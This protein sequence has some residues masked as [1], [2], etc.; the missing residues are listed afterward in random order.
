M[1]H[2]LFA[3]LFFL[4]IISFADVRLPAVIASHMV[5]QQ[6]A[7]VRIWGWCEPGEHVRVKASWDTATYT[8]NGSEKATWSVLIKTPVAGGPYTI[9]ITGFNK[10][11]LD[12]VML[13]EVWVCSGQSNM[14]M[15]MNWGLPYAAE[16]RAA[17][18]NNIRFF[19]IPRTS[20]DYPQDDLKARWA[21]SSEEEMK[22]FS[23]VAYFFG[24]RLQQELN[25]PIGLIHASWSGTPAEVWTPG[26]LVQSDSALKKAAAV[27]S[28]S[29]WWPVNPGAAF[30]AMLNPLT[31]FSISGAIYYQGESNV[32]AADTYTS[33]MTTMIGGWRKKWQKDLP[34]YF[35]Q[36]A[37][38]S[39][40]GN[41]SSAAFLREAQTGVLSYPGT[42]MVL[43][44]DLVD[45]LHDIHPRL[46]KE[47]GIR[48]AN[49]ALAETYH[50]QGIIYKSPL[51][52]SMQVEKDKIRIHFSSAEGGLV[53]R[54]A[55]TEFYIAGED[56][57]FIPAQ[58]RIE[59]STV[60]VWSKE[61]KKPVAVRF[62]FRN[63][64][65]PNLFSKGGLP[66]GIFRT[67]NWPVHIVV[68]AQ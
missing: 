3:V 38:Y 16:A 52:K 51:Y 20:S 42:G 21:V 48:L 13:G 9:T 39:G 28:P 58:A 61:V 50:K 7:E 62:G 67:D 30:N 12:D 46:K 31:R 56:R 2:L 18:N 37:P 35:V 11:V 29:R 53:S 14:E 68:N 32:G 34:F 27:L 36:I 19:H 63:A 4:P 66:V 55:P 15:S 64:A 47:V 6:N 17:A 54:G 25:V 49:Y 44:S 65:Q 43:T 23:A 57:K 45:S 41:N 8:D 40:Y 60:V 33:L 59:G 5:L 10:I 22:K 24:L 26:E 1:K